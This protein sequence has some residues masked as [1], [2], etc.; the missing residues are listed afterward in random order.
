[1]KIVKERQRQI[2]EEGYDSERDDRYMM[3]G[4]LA[5]AAL[6]YAQAARENS[7]TMSSWWPWSQEYW[8]PCKKD[9]IEVDRERCLVKSGALIYAEI[10]RLNRLGIRV[11]NELK[12]IKRKEKNDIH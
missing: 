4:E 10:D 12:A 9:S 1:M 2:T 8:K 7:P 6:C 3:R 5:I 11:V